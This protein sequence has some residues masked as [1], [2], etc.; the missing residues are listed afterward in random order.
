MKNLHLS[1]V[2]VGPLLL[3]SLL[4]PLLLAQA[5]SVAGG[6]KPP[7]A[8]EIARQL[9]SNNQRR[10]ALLTH[11]QGCRRYSLDYTGFPSA[12]SAAMTVEV[13]FNAPS[14]KQFRVV[15]EEGSEMLR[16]HVFKGLLGSEKEAWADEEHRARTEITPDNYEFRLAGTETVQERPQYILEVTPRSK[17][18]FLYSGKIW[19]DA[20]DFAV[21]RI[22]AE[23]AK[24][25]SFWI[26]HTEI[27]HEYEK[28]GEFW[29][30]ARNTSITK[31][32]FGGTA[33]LHIEYMNYRVG[34]PKTGDK[35]DVCSELPG[36]RKVSS[37]REPESK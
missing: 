26:S 2:L 31:V 21:T 30:P 28:M 35:P 22:S 14:D 20:A 1:S 12:K 24:N 13:T 9:V 10:A 7:P 11:Y 37:T 25:P 4:P 8:A 5:G 18:K 29:L 27:E 32:R 33:K 17:S 36:E 6:E 15:H 23:P 34:A 3:A 19:V 16:N